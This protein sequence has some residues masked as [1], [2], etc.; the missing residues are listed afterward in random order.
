MVNMIHPFPYIPEIAHINRVSTFKNVWELCK[1]VFSTAIWTKT[2]FDPAVINDLEN[3]SKVDYFYKKFRSRE[4]G[5]WCGLNSEFLQCLLTGYEIKNQ[6]YNH[7][8][9]NGGFT[10]VMNRV[11][12]EG[13]EYLFGP[14]F[15][16]YYADL[17]G[18]PLD[19]D[20]LKSL[21]KNKEYEEI[22]IIYGG[23]QISKPV[24]SGNK[25][26][27]MSPLAF[28]TLELQGLY[29]SGLL[30]ILKKKFNDENLLNL[31]LIEIV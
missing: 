24:Y 12:I 30:K 20:D 27:M 10:H 31:L 14:Y 1:F 8:I 26:S 3:N 5:G 28:E 11:Y 21:I 22:T 7:G 6:I 25:I 19:F 13:A 23:D 9:S 4:I 15:C 17:K 16:R 2:P 18:N 29:N